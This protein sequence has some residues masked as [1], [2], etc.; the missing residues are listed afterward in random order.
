MTGIIKNFSQFVKQLEPFLNV[1]AIK[2]EPMDSA[3]LQCLIDA[4]K[5]ALK[6]IPEDI[7]ED[8][9]EDASEDAV[10]DKLDDWKITHAH[11]IEVK[12]SCTT[13]NH[14]ALNDIV[15]RTISPFC[16]AALEERKNL[17]LNTLDFVYDYKTASKIL[18][19]NC[20]SYHPKTFEL[21]QFVLK[22]QDNILPTLARYS[23]D[24]LITQV[25]RSHLFSSTAFCH[26]NR[27]HLKK[28]QDS[29]KAL[30]HI[31]S[32]HETPHEAGTFILSPLVTERFRRMSLYPQELSRSS[33]SVFSDSSS[34]ASAMQNSSN[35]ST[36]VQER[37][38]QS[39]PT[40]PTSSMPISRPPSSFPASSS[41]P[42]LSFSPP[43]V[44]RLPLYQLTSER[45][46][47]TVVPTANVPEDMKPPAQKTKRTSK[48]N[49]R[50]T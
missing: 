25:E 2:S 15:Q 38:T 47:L 44:P 46:T 4:L 26:W 23:L 34:S 24:E 11:L 32:T 35:S 30:M 7:P 50:L 20:E 1:E 14:P 12:T 5:A 29:L 33:P 41:P 17:C 16:A 8:A 3:L 49:K 27:T 18:H 43:Y 28:L 13:F 39:L 10:K 45:V 48:R 22:Q 21:L 6:D 36:D 19:I 9:S 31:S 40:T 37:N 42:S